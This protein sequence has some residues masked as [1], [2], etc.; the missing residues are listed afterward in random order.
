MG[1]CMPA[2]AHTCR[3][4][5]PSIE[6]IKNRSR[7]RNE[8]LGSKARKKNIASSPDLEGNPYDI[9]TSPGVD[10][11]YI[12]MSA[13]EHPMPVL[14]NSPEASIPSIHSG[15]PDDLTDD[16]IH[17]THEIQQTWGSSQP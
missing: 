8:S 1:I 4:H 10:E 17:L 7:S 13:F 16:C 6:S 2:A 11:N 15:G 12:K 9:K 14:I 5:L 3:H